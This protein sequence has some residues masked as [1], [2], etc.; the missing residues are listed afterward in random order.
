MLEVPD[1]FILTVYLSNDVYQVDFE[2][3]N[4]KK[5]IEIDKILLYF[6]HAYLSVNP[7]NLNKKLFS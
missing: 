1:M 4:K 3:Y 7:A 5:Y 2:D 6:H